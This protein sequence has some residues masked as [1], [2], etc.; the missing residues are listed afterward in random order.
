M[1]GG[2]R[3]TQG[4]NP[5]KGTLIF[6]TKIIVRGVLDVMKIPRDTAQFGVFIAFLL[7]SFLGEKDGVSCFT[8]YL[9]LLGSCW[10]LCCLKYKLWFCFFQACHDQT[11][12]K[13]FLL[14]FT[15]A[16]RDHNSKLLLDPKTNRKL[17]LFPFFFLLSLL[18]L[19]SLSISLPISLSLFISTYTLFLSLYL[20]SSLSPPLSFFFF[21]SLS[22][23]FYFFFLSPYFC[24]FI[25][26]FLSYSISLSISK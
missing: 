13:N 3:C 7:T 24:L 2:H 16:H 9:T 10:E 19:S 14:T 20:A 15:A 6:F 22:F 17:S 21:L 5:G 26:L 25:T 11:L 4:E 23:L 18:L 12:S 8:P 1:G